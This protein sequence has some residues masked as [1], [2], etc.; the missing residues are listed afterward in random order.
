MDRCIID[1]SLYMQTSE[2]K[3]NYMLNG[4]ALG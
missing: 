2:L 4:A 1:A 3:T